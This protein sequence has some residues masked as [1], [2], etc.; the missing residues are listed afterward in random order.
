V[1]S[2]FAVPCTFAPR[3]YVLGDPSHENTGYIVGCAVRLGDAD[4]VVGHRVDEGA[5]PSKNQGE[6]LA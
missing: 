6:L 3:G 4:E 5:P 1:N 2:N